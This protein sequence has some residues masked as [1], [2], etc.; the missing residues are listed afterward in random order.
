[1]A[2]A[3]RQCNTKHI[4]QFSM[5]RATPEA[6]DAAI[7][8]LLAQYHPSSRQGNSKQNDNKKMYQKDWPF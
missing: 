7:R 5:S 1:M 2:M 8:Q 3:V 6:L 4:A